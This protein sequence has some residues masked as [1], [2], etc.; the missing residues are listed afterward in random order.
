MNE[1]LNSDGHH[2]YQQNKQSSSLTI[3]KKETVTYDVGNPIKLLFL[4]YLHGMY[5]EYS[6]INTYMQIPSCISQCIPLSSQW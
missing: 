3:H 2:Q 6:V 5:V 1:S 4:T